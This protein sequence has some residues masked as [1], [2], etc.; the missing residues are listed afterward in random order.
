MSAIAASSVP[1]WYE[2]RG[3]TG[4][5][6]LTARV[7]TVPAAGARMIDSIDTVSVRIRPFRVRSRCCSALA[8]ATLASSKASRLTSSSDLG[9]TPF[10]ESSWARSNSALARS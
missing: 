6:G 8:T 10:R 3:T 7:R 4:S 2:V 5:P 9:R 1:G